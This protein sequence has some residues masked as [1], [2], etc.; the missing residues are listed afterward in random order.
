MVLVQ[1]LREGLVSA[2]ERV[3]WRAIADDLCRLRCKS[4]AD[5]CCQNAQRDLTTGT[6]VSAVRLLR[7]RR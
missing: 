1:S 2:A 7:T 3:R 6:P 5:Q 4:I